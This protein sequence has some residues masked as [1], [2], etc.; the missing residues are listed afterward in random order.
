ML[1]NS[2][3]QQYKNAWTE[4]GM[5]PELVREVLE[6][7]NI[8]LF[9]ENNSLLK[10]GILTG[11][12]AGLLLVAKIACAFIRKHVARL[13]KRSYEKNT[14]EKKGGESQKIMDDALFV[15]VMLH[16]RHFI[17]V[18]I[19]FWGFNEIDFGFANKFVPIIF[20]G[21]LIWVGI[22]FLLAFIPFNLDLYF[23]KHGTTLSTSQ[24]RS[25]MPIIKGLIWALGLTVL[26]DNIGFHVSAILASLGI[27]GVAAGLAGQ[28]ILSDFFSYLV[29]LL[30]KPFKIGD[31]VVLSSGK[32]GE[33]IY[34]GPKNTRL[35]SLN[36]NVIICAN[37]EMTKGVLENQGSVKEREV[38]VD[39]GV[40][41]T[42]PMEKVKK[43]PAL[44]KEIV[45]SFPQCVFERACMN[46]FGSA[47][48]NFQLIYRVKPQPGGLVAFMET[49]T[50]VNLAFTKRMGDEQINGAYP[51]QSV[52]LTETPPPAPQPAPKPE[53]SEAA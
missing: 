28:A 19:L 34:L 31:F 17:Y 13:A 53:K 52:L 43:V 33:V 14:R 23:R 51:T 35:L 45:E 32:S 21:A 11:M 1:M 22:N 29:I 10:L 8:R 24:S 25:L 20:T 44:L 3:N 49:Q 36:N 6:F 27:A 42:V 18:A 39:V 4:D 47:N 40:A 26:L 30:D 46:N 41:Y 50:A 38:I 5:D 15:K 2:Q 7:F 16:L 37:S 48:Y 9:F 12:V